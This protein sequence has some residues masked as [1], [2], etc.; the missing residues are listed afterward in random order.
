M[1]QLEA[2]L[3]NKQS[4]LSTALKTMD[5]SGLGCCFVVKQDRQMVGILSDGDVRRA[6]LKGAN[7]AT[8]VVEIMNTNFTSLPPTAQNPEILAQLNNRISILPLIDENGVVVDYANHRRIRR[9]PVAEPVLAGNELAYITEAVQSTWISSKG[10]FV[11]RFQ[12]QFAEYCQV[13]YA[14]AVSNGTVALH[15]ALVAMGIGEGDEVIVPDL[16]F[17]ASIN[18]IIYAGATPVLIDVDPTSYNL[19]TDQLEALITPKTKAIMPVHLYGYPADMDAVMDIAERHNLMVLEDAAEALGSTYKGK[20]VGSFGVAATFSFFGNKTVTTGEGGMIVFKDEAVF[21][22]AKI[23][24]DH[25]MNPQKRYWHD[26]VGFNYRLTNLQAA[27]GVAQMERVNELVA[28]KRQLAAEYTRTLQAN[29]VLGLPLDS[30][31]AVNSFWLYTLELPEGTDRDELMRA[32]MH[33]GIETR[34]VFYPL[35]TM[36]PYQQYVQ[37]GQTFPGSLQASS[38]GLSLPSAAHLSPDE[39]RHVATTLLEQLAVAEPN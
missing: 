6:L 19:R 26:E 15:L 12:E 27:I 20:P 2:L 10:K 1:P 36:P 4:D 29:P 33:A 31:D 9:I 22:R 38:R 14:L 37:A 21:N 25:G 39:A 13:P 18:S 34:P 28:G 3:V 35:H 7:L 32:M 24:R 5:E 23:L 30:A 16:T 8:S 11:D 17:A